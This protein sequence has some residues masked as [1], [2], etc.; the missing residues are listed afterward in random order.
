MTGN[1][2]H[3]TL[4]RLNVYVHMHTYR[5]SNNETKNFTLLCAVPDKTYKLFDAAAVPQQG[6]LYPEYLYN[7]MI[8]NLFFLRVFVYTRTHKY[9]LRIGF[10]CLLGF[11][12]R[13]SVVTARARGVLF[14]ALRTTR[15]YI[16][17]SAT[18]KHLWILY[19]R[20]VEPK[21]RGRSRRR[22]N[23]SLHLSY[24]CYWL[25]VSFVFN[26]RKSFNSHLYTTDVGIRS[27]QDLFVYRT[28]KQF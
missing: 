10:A 11:I 24:C 18:R 9:T 28:F 3:I 4:A 6:E 17:A 1:P 21:G 12:Y 22:S 15:L 16:Y 23:L 2:D 19:K 14:V 27:F 20:A 26:I 7:L 13:S 25:V 5:R 8:C